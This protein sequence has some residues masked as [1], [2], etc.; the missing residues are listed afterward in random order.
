MQESYFLLVPT[1]TH[2]AATWLSGLRLSAL[3]LEVM[4]TEDLGWKAFFFG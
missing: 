1:E 3:E 4:V 2:D